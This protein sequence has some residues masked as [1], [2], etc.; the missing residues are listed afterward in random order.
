MS[1]YRFQRILHPTDFS[2][3]DHSAFCHALRIGLT[4]RCEVCFLHVA[5]DH[6]DVDWADFPHVR[7]LLR[8]WE[9]IPEDASREMIRAAGIRVKK[10][11]RSGKNPVAE[12]SGYLEEHPT[13]LVVLATHQRTGLDAWMHHS[14]S[15]AIARKTTALTLFIPRQTGGF[16]TAATGEFR[17]KNILI[18]IAKRPFG[19]PAVRAAEALLRLFNPDEAHINCL[20]V[21]TP[22]DAPNIALP[23]DDRWTVES[24]CW[25][26]NVVEHILET[27]K[28][29]DTDLIIMATEGHHGFLDA[30]RGS[31]TEQVVKLAPCPVLAVP[32]GAI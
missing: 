14:R 26:G 24:N 12:I 9:I 1:E 15:E 31:T 22:E 30:M 29:Q 5:P 10:A 20:H 8:D 2:N 6:H 27:S 21:G 7:D 4:A 28:T 16:I 13:D 23:N 19:G 32:S 3:G 25:R 11:I 17:L 18:P